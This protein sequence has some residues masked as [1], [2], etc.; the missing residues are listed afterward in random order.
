MICIDK[1]GFKLKFTT[2]KRKKRVRLDAFGAE[3]DPHFFNEYNRAEGFNEEDWRLICSRI[4]DMRLQ[5]IRMMIMPEWFEPNKATGGHFEID[6]KD[7]DWDNGIGFLFI[8]R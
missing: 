4:R 2:E 8:S 3:L 5:K 1:G 6:L 7:F